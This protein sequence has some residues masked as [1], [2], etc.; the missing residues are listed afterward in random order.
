MALCLITSCTKK[1][2]TLQTTQP[3]AE[4]KYSPKLNS[5]I[6]GELRIGGTFKNFESLEEVFID[7]N[8]IYPNIDTVYY[9]V[10]SQS[11]VLNKV[12]VGAEAPDIVFTDS[13]VWDYPDM[14][15]EV[16]KQALVLSDPTLEIGM[17]II[18]DELV[19]KNANGEVVFYP[20]FLLSS[21]VLV[22]EKILNEC[23][24]PIPTTYSEFITACENLR[25]AGYNF[26]VVGH[27]IGHGWEAL[28]PAIAEGYFLSNIHQNR[29]AVT[30]INNKTPE[31]EQYLRPTLEFVQ[32]FVNQGFID[33]EKSDAITNGYDN[34]IM[35]FFEGDIPFMFTNA[36]TVTGMEKRKIKSEAFQN[37]P[38][39]YSFTAFPYNDNG[40]T[41][42]VF[43]IFGFVLNKESA[44]KDLAVEF[45]RFLS[46]K[47]ILNKL[48]DLK[49]A[50]RITKNSEQKAPLEPLTNYSNRIHADFQSG[51]TQNEA[52][53]VRN[54]INAVGK[55]SSIDE[56]LQAFFNGEFD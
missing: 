33:I 3:V 22:N 31:A 54:L 25:K 46:Q 26:P 10:D 43:D 38:F 29:A 49:G 13:Y 6:S 18:Y 4:A 30:A 51:V 9:Y 16:Q 55:G 53:I 40:G 15:E 20:A 35:R 24:I 12:V 47:E 8:K 17:S 14:Y 5:D 37:S 42:P 36:N 7:F 1:E 48:C 19:R 32:K 23:N 39:N 28:Y 11:A 56:A 21:G 27:S 34:V 41:L 45:M 44:N 52:A 50:P 2:E